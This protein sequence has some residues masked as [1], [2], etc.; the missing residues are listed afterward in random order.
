MRRFVHFHALRHPK[1]MGGPEVEAF[2][3]H[4]ATARQVSP[5]T[6]HQALC[7]LLS[8]TGRCSRATPLLFRSVL[9]TLT[10]THRPRGS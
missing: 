9:Y 2:L 3:A 1:E 7:A 8:C 4:L 10:V 6:P 5:S